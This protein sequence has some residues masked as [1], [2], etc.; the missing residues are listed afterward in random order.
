MF[1]GL[2]VVSFRSHSRCRTMYE[3]KKQQQQ[4]S[5][6]KNDEKCI[7]WTSIALNKIKKNEEILFFFFF[8]VFFIIRFFQKTRIQ[9][10]I[11]FI[12]KYDAGISL[13]IIRLWNW[14]GFLFVFFTFWLIFKMHKPCN[15]T[16]NWVDNHHFRIVHHM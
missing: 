2:L 6:K 15:L 11:S 1:F 3:K 16:F 8:F 7:K 10:T 13:Y 12:Y 9:Y 5:W 4:Q 14:F